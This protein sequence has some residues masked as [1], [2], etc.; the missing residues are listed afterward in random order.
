MNKAILVNLLLG[1][2][3]TACGGGGSDAPV[4]GGDGKTD[5]SDITPNEFSFAQLS[6][7]ELA[8]E[9]TSNQI[10]IS[11]IDDSTPISIENGSYSINGAEY[12][13]KVG[14]INNDD[15]LTIKAMSSDVFEV[16]IKATITVG[17]ISEH[18]IAV[19]REKDTVPTFER[20]TSLTNTELDTYVEFDKII[21]T[22]FDDDD[23]LI[24]GAQYK[25]NDGTWND[26]G[27]TS[28][29]EDDALSLRIK[30]S[31]LYGEQ[32][33][34]NISGNNWSSRFSATTKDNSE[35]T[36]IF[37]KDFSE[38]GT[39]T[40]TGSEVLIL[41]FSESMK[42]DTL[43]L[44]GDMVPKCND[45]ES[46]TSCLNMTWSEDNSILT[47][48]PKQDFY[49]YSSLRSLQLNITGESNLELNKSLSATVLPTFKTFQEAS[50]VIG[51]T[52]FDK[53]PRGN[54]ST[55]LEFPKAVDV[56]TEED[57]ATLYIGDTSNNRIIKYNT[58]PT[59][60][61][62]A[63][64]ERFGQVFS[65]GDEPGNTS[66]KL[67][68]PRD[69]VELNGRV[70]IADFYNNRGVWVSKENFDA[71]QETESAG[72]AS[73]LVGQNDF[74][75]LVEDQCSAN[76]LQYISGM[77]VVE[78]GNGI[79]WVISDYTN[80]RV[81]IWSNPTESKGS[82]AS[83]VL[84]QE[85]FDSCEEKDLESDGLNSIGQPMNIWSNGKN[86]IVTTRQDR[87]LVWNDFPT[88]S[89]ESPDFQLGQLDDL[90]EGKNHNNET[91]Q[92]G[93][94]YPRGIGGN[95]HQICVADSGNHRVLVW[96]KIPISNNDLADI[97][98]GQ[99]DFEKNPY[100]DTEQDVVTNISPNGFTL[101]KP[102]DCDMS[103]EQLFIADE[104]NNRV[105]V[106]DA[107][108]KR[109]TAD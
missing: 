90:S 82:A 61:G 73:G 98:R 11:G 75:E 95:K 44:S 62:A 5:T 47:L 101:N 67:K 60:N 79:Q 99:S 76:G 2:T 55:T 32:V 3:L 25:I 102:N 63:H 26:P 15:S 45:S 18:F 91:S 94:D 108:N 6:N 39:T 31:H 64:D 10:T 24:E 89:N 104:Y 22:E 88:Q 12:T 49:W 37:E 16:E 93:L 42:T 84:G 77:D 70:Y 51:Q 85:N 78:T 14:L 19:T 107:L 1:L 74:G 35:L 40:I 66:D 46:E 72:H 96:S 65:Q 13:Y 48:S 4:E 7:Q 59:E 54:S 29:S 36:V 38:N 71:S 69:S 9:V 80:N 43:A 87:I 56:N 92:S 86:L 100:N 50:V 27:T 53:T 17:T 57:Q 41:K 109:P 33:Y 23:I 106:F 52:Q 68:Y 28:I 8:N 103:M 34:T 30:T 81:M 58:I 105:L 21:F 20:P 97:V 83:I